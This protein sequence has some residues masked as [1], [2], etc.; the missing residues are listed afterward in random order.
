VAPVVEPVTGRLL[1][2]IHAPDAIRQAVWP[3]G[4][5]RLADTPY[6]AAL[7]AQ[8]ALEIYVRY[9][10]DPAWQPFF[11]AIEAARA[12]HLHRASIA[13]EELRRDYFFVR[14][15]DLLSLTFCNAWRDDQALEGRFV[16]RLRAD[17]L[18]ATPDPFGGTSVLLEVPGIELSSTQFSSASEALAAFQRGRASRV[19]GAVTGA[20]A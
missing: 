1:D 7:V 12:R 9:R 14:A 3:R 13:L 18:V 2:F 10:A 15:G 5:E 8:H 16:A 20:G 19:R 6:A 17:E 4:V 11:T